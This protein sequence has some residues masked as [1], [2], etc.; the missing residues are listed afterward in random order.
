M[1]KPELKR[2]LG[3]TTA[4]LLVISSMIGSGIFKKIAPMS[5]T[6]MDSNL[7]LLAWVIAGIV[8][9]FGVF[10]YS[11]L[12]TLTE[13]GGGQFE[14]FRIIY[15]KFFAFIFGWTCFT[16]IQTASIASIAYVFGESVNN[17]AHFINPFDGLKEINIGNYIFPFA[18]SGVKIFTIITIICLTIINIYGVKKGGLLNDIFSS[19]K[20]IGIILL[21][22][23]GLALS[24]NSNSFESSGTIIQLE[25]L[26]GRTLFS[27]MFTAMLAAFWAYDGW[28]NISYIGGEVKN[29][30]KNIP[31]A[32]I[33]GTAIVM[34]I[35]VVLNYAYLKALPVEAYMQIDADGNKIAGAE[36]AKAIMGSGGFILISVLIMLCTFGA[37]NSS[38]MSSPRIY[39]QMAKQNLFFKSFGEIHQKYHTPHKSLIFQAMWASVLVISGTFD[40][41]TDMLIFASFIFYGSGAI[42]LIIM[43]RKGI[44]TAKIFGYPYIPIIFVLF[45]ILLVGNALFSTPRESL[46]GLL[47]LAS[48][49]PLYY[50]LQKKNS[51]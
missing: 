3:L 39:F 23:L 38:L 37:T 45:C 18:N 16:V 6:L 49:I 43:K 41:L 42:G 26:K 22:I 40:Q 36:M 29:P 9:M 2:A 20:I 30:K 24:G 12:A 14:Y 31:I 25:T 4:I 27:A 17:V 8:S 10:T 32:I 1:N 13:E 34:F 7:I 28:I 47:F 11:G 15:G 33:G 21:I 19:A 51:N 46:T 44:I 5:T 50:Y 35:Y 48:S